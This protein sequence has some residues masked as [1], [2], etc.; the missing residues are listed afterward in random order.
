MKNARI[1]GSRI[2]KVADEKNMSHS[3]L[4][5][6]IN[7]NEKQFTACI[8]GK[9]FFSFS[10]LC[11]IANVLEVNVCEFLNDHEG[12]DERGAIRPSEDFKEPID[13]EMVGSVVG[14]CNN[15]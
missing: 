1:I 8:R 4:S 5:K 7:C 9:R 3:E 6:A 12:E 11:L 13:L 10:Q 2:A 14:G 15:A